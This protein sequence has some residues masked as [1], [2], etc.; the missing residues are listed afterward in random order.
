M[1]TAHQVKYLRLVPTVERTPSVKYPSWFYRQERGRECKPRLMC[2]SND[3]NETF[4]IYNS[5]CMCLFRFSG[6]I[7]YIKSARSTVF[8]VEMSRCGC[9]LLLWAT[10]QLTP[11]VST[12]K[13]LPC[14]CYRELRANP[15]RRW[16]WN[17]EGPRAVQLMY[18]KRDLQEETNRGEWGCWIVREMCTYTP[19]IDRS[20]W[21]LHKWSRIPQAASASKN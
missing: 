1:Y 12:Q 3:P 21:R 11:E 7:I 6:K 14:R 9:V 2:L 20:C 10:P 17:K 5:R 16:W 18:M 13:M 4:R 15:E 19:S 8:M